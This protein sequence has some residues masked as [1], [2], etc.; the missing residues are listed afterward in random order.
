MT[1]ERNLWSGWLALAI[2]MV[3][4]TGIAAQSWVRVRLHRDRTIE[5]TGSAKRRIVS[6]L[7]Q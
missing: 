6:D 4:S 2:G 7:I 3:L 1:Q 5:I